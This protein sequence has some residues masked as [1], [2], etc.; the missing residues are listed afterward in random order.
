M[1]IVVDTTPAWTG[2]TG[3]IGYTIY[4]GT[5]VLQARTT[6]GIVELPAGSGIYSA[7]VA[8]ATLAG[9]WVVW[10]TDNGS[11]V[12]ASESFPTNLAGW[13]S[14]ATLAR[15]IWNLAA[16]AYV[17]YPKHD[18][19][20]YREWV[21][22]AYLQL[23]HQAGAV[24][25]RTATV[26]LFDDQQT[27]DLPGDYRQMKP[28]GVTL[29]QGAALFCELAYLSERDATVEYL[30]DQ[31]SALSTGYWFPD[32]TH[33]ALHPIPVGV[34]DA[35]TLQLKYDAEMPSDLTAT[36][37]LPIPPHY[38]TALIA[39]ALWQAA[40]FI[41]GAEKFALLQ[42]ARWERGL[43]DWSNDAKA[44]MGQFPLQRKPYTSLT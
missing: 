37:S 38:E 8:D 32:A 17:L 10:D 18:L 11:P 39:Y 21:R 1:R 25:T 33:L 30:T 2:L 31:A 13:Q 5:T 6:A 3:T 20:F 12:Y 4:N 34:T 36:A 43:K 24:Y 41:D 26:A 9:H 42:Q 40:M 27:Y 35:Y 23:V 22:D 15:S 29:W 14:G 7:E 16:R 19:L 28:H 44:R